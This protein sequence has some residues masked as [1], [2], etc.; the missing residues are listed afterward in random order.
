MGATTDVTSEK[1]KLKL[2]LGKPDLT[3]DD[4]NMIERQFSDLDHEISHLSNPKDDVKWTVF[5][6]TSSRD[7][8]GYKL[9]PSDLCLLVARLEKGTATTQ[10]LRDP[11]HITIDKNPKP[12]NAREFESSI[13]ANVEFVDHSNRFS[14]LGASFKTISIHDSDG[15][16]ASLPERSP[17]AQSSCLNP[18]PWAYQEVWGAYVNQCQQPVF[19]QWND[20][21]RHVQLLDHCTNTSGP[22][23]WQACNP[24]HHP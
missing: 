14:L 5:E 13:L 4:R 2:I 24:S 20:G 7:Y 21:C 10:W 12:G 19:R 3:S 15:L 9:F 17:A 6:K 8:F 1:D 16:E 23:V 18:H 22:V 11:I